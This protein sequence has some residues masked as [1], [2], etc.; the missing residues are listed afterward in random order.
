MIDIATDFNSARN[1]FENF[2][3]FQASLRKKMLRKAMNA[4]LIPIL[5]D[6]KAHV[7]DDTGTTNKALQSK[8]SVKPKSTTGLVGIRRGVKAVV[9]IVKR[10]KNKGKVLVIVPSR[11]ANQLERGHLIVQDGKVVGRV[12]PKPFMR[13][14]WDHYGGDNAFYTFADSMSEQIDTE[15][16]G[17]A[18]LKPSP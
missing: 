13:P 4:T 8:V 2:D 3:F 6:A 17:G 14:A 15:I 11:H 16:Q 9:R 7:R 18:Y 10:G 1:L 5:T 12:P